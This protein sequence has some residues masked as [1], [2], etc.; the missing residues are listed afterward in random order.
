MYYKPDPKR[1]KSVCDIVVKAP[2]FVRNGEETY[3]NLAVR[4]ILGGIGLDLFY[5]E[6]KKRAMLANEMIDYMEGQRAKFA[7]LDDGTDAFLEAKQGI[8]V[9]AC[10]RGSS[11]GHVAVVCPDPMALSGSWGKMVPMLANVG[12]KNGVMRASLCFQEE[13]T[14]YCVLPF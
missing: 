4:K 13:P 12:K 9:I 1:L 10:E 3:C 6:A 5:H 7:K 8:V 11:H 14:Y 2:E